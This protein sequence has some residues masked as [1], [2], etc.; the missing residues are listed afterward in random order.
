MT[1]VLAYFKYSDF[2][3]STVNA[4]LR[5][6][7]LPL[8]ESRFDIML[9]IGISF[10]TFQTMG[11]LADV[12]RGEIKAERNLIK[13]ALF[14][15]FFPQLLSGPISRA[16]SLLT[17]IDTIPVRKVWDYQRITGGLILMLWGY[18]VKLVI[19]D[20]ISV[21]VDT[22]FEHYYIYGTAALTVGAVGFAIQ[23]YG[24]FGGYSLIAIGAA[25]VLG[26]ELAAN[27]K[28][29]YLAQGIG[30]FW[31][32]WHISLSSW[33]RDYVY[34][35]LG[36]NRRGKWRKYGN[37]LITFGVSGLWH[38]ADWTFVIW[39]LLH[40]CYQIL[41]SGLRPLVT[42]VNQRAGT[43]TASFG[44]RLGK[45]I[46]TFMMVDF[47]WIFFR[48]DNV[49]TAFSYI[50]QMISNRDWWSFFD[51][52][53]YTLGL[54]Y[55]ECHIL[56]FALLAL[57]AVDWLQQKKKMTID[58]FLKEQWIVFRWVVVL[59]LLFSTLLFGRYGPGFD[60]AEF[61]YSQF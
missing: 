36:G 11:Y 32:R 19:A 9:P 39:G 53:L 51:G 3:I 25:Q 55:Q 50:G 45:M 47:A 49:R 33:L 61:I 35:P 17:Q 15:A 21:V 29:P 10:Y 4:C 6:L 58:L 46:L 43:K 8:W 52:S 34:I 1:G 40:G 44:Y 54:N 30:E 7:H 42:W 18:F 12:C 28:A 13:Y 38:G 31:R 60:S 20:R 22:V 59:L 16:K 23:I 41:E 57:L 2:L 26:F 24:D 48:A 27:F 5:S 56:F 37:L 14:V